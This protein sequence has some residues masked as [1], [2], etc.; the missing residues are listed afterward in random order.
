MATIPSEQKGVPPTNANIDKPSREAF[1]RGYGSALKKYL[2]AELQHELESINSGST[3]ATKVTGELEIKYSWIKYGKVGLWWQA[4]HKMTREDQTSAADLCFNLSTWLWR[5][6]SSMCCPDRFIA[7]FPEMWILIPVGLQLRVLQCWVIRP[8][9][10]TNRFWDCKV[11]SDP[12]QLC[13]WLQDWHLNTALYTKFPTFGHWVANFQLEWPGIV[14]IPRWR[15]TMKKTHVSAAV[16]FSLYNVKPELRMLEARG[17]AVVVWRRLPG[18]AK[19]C[20]LCICF[21]GE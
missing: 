7:I 12:V 11:S 15:Q 18:S 21:E 4:E 19:Q 5:V 6:L 14:N 3:E 16:W 20:T 13:S 8:G 17:K 9:H 10:S 1:T 2:K